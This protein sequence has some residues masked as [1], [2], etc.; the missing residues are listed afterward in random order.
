MVGLK[1]VLVTVVFVPLFYIL[2]KYFSPLPFFILLAAGI[3]IGQY[4]FY[5]F[6][7][8]ERINVSIALG[9]ICGFLLAISFYASNSHTSPTISVSIILILV[10]V[11]HLFTVKNIES[12]LTDVSITFFGI[13][14]I[15][16]LMGHIILL[17]GM[18]NGQSLIFFLFLV[19]W[20]GDAGAY[21][22]GSYFGKHRL[23]YVISPKKTYEGAAGC[24]A[25]SILMAF[26]AKYWFFS[27]LTVNDTIILGISFGIISQLGDFSESLLKRSAGV[28]D[29]SF[30]I[31][32]HG[33]ILDRIDSLLFTAPLLYYYIKIVKG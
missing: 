8:R 11:A 33:G 17:R 3:M 2:V 21:Y 9:I 32:A 1:R 22:T 15:G 25:F 13:F 18:E 14:Y 5:R 7:Y 10:L 29:S 4:E 6:F 27:H 12:A 23:S 31:P 30:L 24:F 16:W 28:K 19:T 20:A 26:I